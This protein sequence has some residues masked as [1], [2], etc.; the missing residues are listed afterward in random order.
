M[1]RMFLAISAAMIS[2]TS[3]TASASFAST[4]NS[5]NVQFINQGTSVPYHGEYAGYYNAKV[6]GVDT[7]VMCDDFTALINYGQTW[8]A[9]EFTYADV[10]SGASTK[11]SGVSKY[12]QAGWLFGQTA[13]VTPSVRAQM[14]GAIWNIMTPGSVVMD[15]LALSYYMAATNGTHNSYDWSNVMKVL[16]PTPA[17]SGQE[18]LTAAP[19]PVPASVWLLGSGLLGLVGVSRR[20]A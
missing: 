11:F 12:S 1:R 13:A 15:P 7:I 9:N 2:L 20:P 4:V 10:M 8:Q 19:V 3:M 5:V 17:A 18:F 16:T 14:Q 6:D